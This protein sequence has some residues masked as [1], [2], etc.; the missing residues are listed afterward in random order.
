MTLF[1]RAAGNTTDNHEEN[2]TMTETTDNAAPLTKLEQVIRD[3][4]ADS[5]RR[6]QH[7]QREKELRQQREDVVKPLPILHDRLAQLK[8]QVS[9]LEGQQAQLRA[10]IE[11]ARVLRESGGID[12]PVEEEEH[13][14]D[15]I[16]K[17]LVPLRATLDTLQQHITEINDQASEILRQAEGQRTLSQSYDRDLIV[18]KRAALLEEIHATRDRLLGLLGAAAVFNG[19]FPRNLV[20]GTPEYLRG[21]GVP[22]QPVALPPHLEGVQPLDPQRDRLLEGLPQAY[23]ARLFPGG[24]SVNTR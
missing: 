22:Q 13:Q 14:L 21:A 6:Q 24:F 15:D 18:R 19:L 17:R 9:Q 7:A 16:E 8:G 5:E 12:T 11:T 3:E 2:D 20:D 10:N 1:R 4:R 23:N